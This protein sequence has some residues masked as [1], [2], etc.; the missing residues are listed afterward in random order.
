MN[1]GAILA[2]VLKKS[3]VQHMFTLCGG[4]IGPVY[5]E[6]EKAGLQVWDVRHEATA[7]FAADALAR[8]SGV[9]G[10]VAV[11]AGPGVTNA[12]TAL[13]NAQMAQSPLLL[14]G[15]ATATL[16]RRRGALQDIDQAVLLHSTVKM[17]LQAQRLRA[18]GPLARKALRVAHSGVPG[19]VFLE[20]PVDL[21]YPEATVREWYGQKN[22]NAPGLAGKL[23]QWYIQRHLQRLF[24]GVEE[25]NEGVSLNP[26]AAAGQR[27]AGAARAVALQLRYAR[28]PLLL[29]GSGAMLAPQRAAEL[30]E[31]VQRLGIPVF[32]SGM[33][34]GLLG[35]HSA[36]QFQHHR[37]EALRA[38]DL[39]LLAGVPCDFRLDY[40]RHLNRRARTIAISRNRADLRQNLRPYRA[41]CADP[42]AFLVNLAAEAAGLPDWSEWKKTLQTREDERIAEIAQLALEPA[43]GGLNPLALFQRL[44]QLL[45]DRS[46]LV[47]DGGDFAATAAYTLRPRKPLSWLDPGVFGTLG[48]GGGF[49]LGAAAWYPGDYIWIIYGDGSAAYSLAEF[50]TFAK[51]GLKVCGIV[52][53]NGAWEQ[54]ARDQVALLGADTAVRLPRTD[55][56][57]VAEGYGAAGERVDTLEDFEEAIRRALVSMDQGT[58]YLIN[59]MTGATSFRKG[60]ISM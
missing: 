15:G 55:Y 12:M 58:P 28:R 46:V 52:G 50:E 17:E 14:L 48:V 21:L 6:A 11:T 20:L 54:I 7:V 59:A 10:V 4:H 19:P 42:A 24:A 30:A 1:G 43:P 49:A 32:L 35:R 23:A 25:Q 34:R 37:K 47:A 40:G 57:R 60:S 13:K 5:V 53:N 8:L 36:I 18:V 44:E 26:A 29:L 9:P 45:P 16:L 38:A 31:A 51:N 2:E 41:Y 22:K 33:A 27:L 3:G 39:I 56:H